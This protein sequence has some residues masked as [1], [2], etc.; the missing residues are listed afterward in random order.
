MTDDLVQFLRARLDEDESVARDAAMY[1]AAAL[2][3]AA[4]QHGVRQPPYDGATWANDYDHLFVV[5]DRPGQP[6][7]VQIA[8]CGSAAFTLTPHLARHDPARVLAE[9]EAKRR[10]VN[11]LV[12]RMNDMSDAMDGEWGVGAGPEEYESEQLLRLFALPYANHP[13]YRAEWCAGEDP[14]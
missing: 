13:D 6:R 5:Q 4:A 2:A 10:I 12:P 14:S 1:A 3:S 11:E 7:K 8:D 9:V